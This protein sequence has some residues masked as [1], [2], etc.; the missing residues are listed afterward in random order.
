M[1]GE[2]IL[3]YAQIPQLSPVIAYTVGQEALY[4]LLCRLL[5]CGENPGPLEEKRKIPTNLIITKVSLLICPTWKS[6]EKQH[7]CIVWGFFL[8]IFSPQLASIFFRVWLNLRWELHSWIHILEMLLQKESWTCGE[9]TAQH[10]KHCWS[11]TCFC[12]AF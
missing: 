2:E 5:R 1:A 11:N 3:N 10:L 6:L 7:F 12:C 4:L 8:S 9:S